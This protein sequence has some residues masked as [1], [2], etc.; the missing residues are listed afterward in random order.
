MEN[1]VFYWKSFKDLKAMVPFHRKSKSKIPKIALTLV[2]FIF[3]RYFF[4][5]FYVPSMHF[6]KT[7]SVLR[8]TCY[9]PT[10]IQKRFLEKPVNPLDFHMRRRLIVS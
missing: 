8:P 3:L 9:F 5:F 7:T 6:W 1:T 4:I 10:C 2:V